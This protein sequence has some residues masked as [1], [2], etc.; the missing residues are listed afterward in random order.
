MPYYTALTTATVMIAVLA[1]AVYRRSRDLGTL[2]GTA[3]LYYW[4]LYGAWYVVLDKRGGFSGKSYHYLE[5]KMFPLALDSDYLTAICL[6]AG[7][8]I[9]FQVTMLLLLPAAK[10]LPLVRLRLRHE[11]ILLI[12]GA[13]A[14]ASMFLMRNQL[15]NAVTL[16]ESAYIYTRAQT[17]SW[18][19]IHQVLNRVAMLPAAIGLA[20]LLTGSRSRYFVNVPGRYLKFLYLVVLGTGCGFA[21][22]LGNKNEVFAALLTGLLTYAGSLRKPNW[23]RIGLVLL[24]GM[25]FLQTIDFFRGYPLA[26][27]PQAVAEHIG[28]ATGVGRFVTSSNEAWAAHFSMYGVLTYDVEPR[29]GY[30]IYS[31]LCSVVPRILWPDRPDDIYIYYSQSVGTIQNQGY[32]LHHAT[33]WYLNFGYLGVALGAIVLAIV[34]AGC[35]NARRKIRPNSGVAFR[36]LAVT[37][38]ALVPACIPALV[39]AGPE[40]Y[41]GLV[42]DSVLIPLSVLLFAVLM[43]GKVKRARRFPSPGFGWTGMVP[44]PAPASGPASPHRGLRDVFPRK[45]MVPGEG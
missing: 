39:R 20:A 30:S 6:Y 40:A 2:V 31:L 22:T 17:S 3:A 28:D 45:R 11:P 10:E 38:P 19:A 25:W 7:F 37:M 13:A 43:S 32:S 27:L 14:L 42:I 9:C 26:E 34:W 23:I 33:G 4:S 8:I 1:F 16:N 35:L 44:I 15:S 5:R 29:F 21:F 41:K 18:F 24:V 36:I 12:S